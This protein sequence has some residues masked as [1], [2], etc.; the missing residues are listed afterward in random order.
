MSDR[1]FVSHPT[2]AAPPR[3]SVEAFSADDFRVRLGAAAGAPLGAVGEVAPGD[4]CRL[5]PRAQPRRLDLAI[6]GG[7][8]R[9]PAADGPD[10]GVRIVAEH[11]LIAE[12]GETVTVL[13][14]R[15]GGTGAFVLPLSPLVRGADYTLIGSHAR[16]GGLP[17]PDRVAAAFTA[18]THIVAAD[19]RPHPV[20]R[21]VPGMPILTRDHGPQRLRS[22]LRARLRAAG[23]HAPV[24]IAP[25]T[26]G[27]AAELAISPYHRILLYRPG[28]THGAGSP[29]SFVQARHLVDGARIRR[30][31]AG[32]VDYVSLVFDRH[33]VI[34]AEGFPCESL[35]L[36][37]AV[38]DRLPGAMLA[39]LAAHL[40]DLRHVPRPTPVTAHADLADLLR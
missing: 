20:E 6:G 23:D 17:L 16:A 5:A 19:G 15:V 22:L 13:A 35:C 10:R 33:E 1:A 31:E 26:I 30:R 38:T 18:G 37:P 25:G 12:D 4:I 40:P 14:L 24:V 27:N 7:P 2:G 28:G 21:L 3:I 32:Y 34:F 9:S 8:P 39:E 36:T 11:R 29:E